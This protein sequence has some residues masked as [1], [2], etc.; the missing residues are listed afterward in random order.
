M[1]NHPGEAHFCFKMKNKTE[2][3]AAAK[4]KTKATRP[5]T[6]NLEGELAEKVRMEAKYLKTR[7]AEAA[8][9][10]TKLGTIK[11][12]EM[13]RRMKIKL[14][15]NCF[16]TINPEALDPETREAVRK[17]VE[18]SGLSP[19]EVMEGALRKAVDAEKQERQ[20]TAANAEAN[21]EGGE[22]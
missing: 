8:R 16:I 5:I 10:L 20:G 19:A 15:E 17:A 4:T 9:L 22:G 14:S 21:G 2:A 3:T 6:L 13:R 1:T 11:A 12:E 7:P 18:E